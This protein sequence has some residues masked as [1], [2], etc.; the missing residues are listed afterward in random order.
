MKVTVVQMNSSAV[1]EDNLRQAES[2]V[3]E[4]VAADAPDLVAL[5]EMFACLSAEPE[6]LQASAEV[7]SES[8]TVAAFSALAKELQTG[9]HIGSL[10]EKEDDQYYNSTVALDAAGEIVARYRKMHLFDITLPDG[11]EANESASLG[12]GQEVVT[13][14]THGIT[15]GCAI[16]YDLRFPE[17]FRKLRDLDSQLIM[18]PAAFTFQTGSAHWD[19]LVRNRAI[20]WS[21]KSGSKEQKS[22]FHRFGLGKDC[23]LNST[24]GA[25]GSRPCKSAIE[26]R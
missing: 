24:L 22:L 15:V 18:T 14:K 5:P 20:K 9:I 2:L 8:A 23:V 19:L 4:A 12:R 11:T 16:C 13:Y 7:I 21:T 3:R 25:C 26:T 1:K 17:L 10:I 6:I